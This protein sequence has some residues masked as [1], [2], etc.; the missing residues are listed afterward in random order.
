MD[1]KRQLSPL[2][3]LSDSPEPTKASLKAPYFPHTDKER[4]KDKDFALKV[5]DLDVNRTLNWFRM[6]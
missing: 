1:A 4:E 2:S 3:P 6:P 5:N